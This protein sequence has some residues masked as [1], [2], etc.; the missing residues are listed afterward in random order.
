M[1]RTELLNADDAE[2][3]EATGSARELPAG[4]VRVCAAE[5]LIEPASVEPVTLAVWPLAHGLAALW[6]SG[7]MPAS[8]GGAPQVDRLADQAREVDGQVPSGPS[9]EP[10]AGGAIRAPAGDRG[11]E[12]WFRRSG[13]ALVDAGNP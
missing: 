3:L 1:F 6:L 7:R 13:G 11:G 2:L 8:W 12:G 4:E 5:G 10:G 9:R